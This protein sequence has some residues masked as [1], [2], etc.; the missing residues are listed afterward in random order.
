MFS[1]LLFR[2]RKKKEEKDE[3]EV[4]VV[5]LLPSGS[6]WCAT[7]VVVMNLL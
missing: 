4:M 1:S 5:R 3:A 7:L 2:W 6:G